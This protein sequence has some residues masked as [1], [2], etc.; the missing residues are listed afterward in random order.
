V[1]LSLFAVFNARSDERSAFSGLFS[2]LWLWGAVALS[3]GLQVLVVYTPF[4]Q[5]AF[6]TT[7]LSIGDWIKCMVVGSS[8][9][10]LREISK[11]VVRSRQATENRKS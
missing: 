7:N 11:I 8:V 5:K 3:L 9:L 4:L 1:F 10:W 2:N 6:S